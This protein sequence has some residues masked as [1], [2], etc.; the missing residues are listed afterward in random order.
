VIIDSGRAMEPAYLLAV[1]IGCFTPEPILAGPAV[2][3]GAPV[4]HLHREDFATSCFP[5]PVADMLDRS[6]TFTPRP[7]RRTYEWASLDRYANLP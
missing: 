4:R 1:C 2:P 6:P 7:A 5:M 3:N